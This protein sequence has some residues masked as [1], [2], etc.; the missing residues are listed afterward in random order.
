M[1]SIRS[2]VET[3]N[4]YVGSSTFGR[5]FRLEGSGHVRNATSVDVIPHT[6][7][8]IGVGDP[9]HE[10]HDR[11]SGRTDDVLHDV[12]HHRR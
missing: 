4:L 7:Q 1:E 3:F 12:L 5:I 8:V 6:Y 11:A 9:K 2:S 10:V